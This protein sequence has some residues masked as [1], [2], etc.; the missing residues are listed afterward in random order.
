MT[1]RIS[2]T[3]DQL[4]RATDVRT[5]QPLMDTNPESRGGDAMP[6]PV[7]RRNETKHVGGGP[8]ALAFFVA[9]HPRTKGSPHIGRTKAGKAYMAPDS[10]AASEWQKQVAHEASIATNGRLMFG[11]GV[12][13]HVIAE[14]ILQRPKGHFGKLGLLPSAPT[15]HTKK[16]DLDKL[17][18]AIKDGMREI[19]YADDSQVCIIKGTKRHA[20]EGEQSGVW[21]RVQGVIP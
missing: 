20:H 9:G 15:M 3:P 8:L 10:K 1:R 6:E 14:F 7:G 19:V 18:R 12:A 11:Q 16:P 4:A 17:F 13:V 5:G 2:F 21:I